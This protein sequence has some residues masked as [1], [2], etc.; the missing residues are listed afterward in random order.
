MNDIYAAPDA[1]LTNPVEGSEFGSL[2]KGIAGDYDLKYKAVMGEAWNR[3]KGAK[4]TFWLAMLLYIIVQSV[5]TFGSGFVLT[6]ALG[7]AFPV[8]S[9]ILGQVIIVAITTPM[10]AGVT[11]IAIRRAADVSIRATSV[12]D[13]FGKIVQLFVMMLLLYIMLAIGFVLL[14]LPGIYLSVAYMF[15]IPL[16]VEKNLGPW[17]ALEA[18]RKAVTKSWFTVFGLFLSFAFIMMLSMLTAGIA[19]IWTLPWVCIVMGLAYRVIFG[20]EK[21]TLENE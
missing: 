21:A 17:Q 8:L 14:V 1:E 5:V 18:S 3:V 15:A 13:Y 2:E 6:L 16:M 20:V 7:E 11:M 19:L 4:G 12:F 9:S 10:T